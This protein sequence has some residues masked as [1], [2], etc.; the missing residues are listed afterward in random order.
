MLGTMWKHFSSKIFASKML[1]KSRNANH[2]MSEIIVNQFEW[3]ELEK[4]KV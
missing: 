4:K 3:A 2:I 1:I